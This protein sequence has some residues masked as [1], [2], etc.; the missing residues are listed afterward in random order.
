[1]IDLILDNLFIIIPVVV[2]LVF[3]SII[4]R[5]NQKKAQSGTQEEEQAPAAEEEL[6]ST[7][8][9]WESGAPPVQKPP[10]RIQGL[11]PSGIPLSQTPSME[12]VSRTKFFTR[13]DLA[14]T[15]AQPDTSQAFKPGQAYAASQASA[16]AP[17]IARPVQPVPTA[18]I[19]NLNYLPALK[20]AVVFS[21]IISPPVSLRQD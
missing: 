21:E 1:M 12:T 4:A 14:F 16:A 7:L 17:A 11:A 10:E 9:H 18:S 5:V 19:N 15:P 20:K 13:K 6:T 8:G 3:R 2:F